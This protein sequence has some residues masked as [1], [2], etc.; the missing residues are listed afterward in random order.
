MLK[1][2]PYTL[3]LALIGATLTAQNITIFPDEYE[4]VAEGPL[5][6]PN[7]PLAKGTSRV[8]VLYETS[9]LAIPSGHQITRIGFRQDAT[10][11]TL[12]SGRT[13]QLEIRMGYSTQTAAS[14]TTNFANNLAGPTTQV[15]APATFQLP[16]LRDA[17]NPLTNGQFF[18]QLNTPFTYTPANGNLIVEY[19]IYGNSSGGTSWNYRLDRSDYYSPTLLGPNGCAHSGGGTPHLTFAATRP[20][21]TFSAA[22]STGPANSFG[23]LLLAPNNQLVTPFSLQPLVFGIQPTCMGQVPFAASLQLTGFTGTTGAKSWAF[24]IPNAPAFADYYWAGQ[25][26]FFD[27]FSPGGVVVSNGAQVLTGAAP[28][29]SILSQVGPPASLTTGTVNRNY[30]PITFFDHH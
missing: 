17:A 16:N 8:Q 20:G 14:M 3:P 29:T 1:H 4:N 15:F 24:T 27:F 10:L 21:L 28:R 13:L 6:S 18:I 11:T 19:W 7:L 9:D 2:L 26:A 25:A 30:N 22:V 23:L 5:N 12:D